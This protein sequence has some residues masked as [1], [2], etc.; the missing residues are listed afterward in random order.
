MADLTLL[1]ISGSLRA[2]SFNRKLLAEAVRRFAPATY[3]EGDLQLPLYDGDLEEREGI[4]EAVR[5]LTD[6]IAQ[7]DALVISSPE[8]NKGVTGV[9]KN[10]LDWISRVEGF[11]M[12]DKPTAVISANA[13]RTG[14]ETGQYMLR[15]CLVPLRPAV[16]EYPLVLVAGAKDQFDADERLVTESYARALDTLMTRLREAA[17]A[18]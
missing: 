18:R 9:M 17:Q 4:P 3:L 6:Q 12:Q 5:R 7:A 2:G 15:A 10:A 14:G 16:L 11:P 13:G 8:Y 1:G